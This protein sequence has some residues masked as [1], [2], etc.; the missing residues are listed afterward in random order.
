MQKIIQ[1]ADGQDEFSI[2][3]QNLQPYVPPLLLNDCECRT[4]T[5]L[6]LEEGI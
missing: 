6:H 3:Q 2:I 4:P 5:A 1:C